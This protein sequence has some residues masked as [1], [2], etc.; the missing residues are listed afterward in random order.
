LNEYLRLETFLLINSIS[1]FPAGRT[2][3]LSSKRG[4]DK[5]W[6]IDDCLKAWSGQSHHVSTLKL[7]LSIISKLSIRRSVQSH[8]IRKG[9]LPYLIELMR[10]PEP[11]VGSWEE[12]SWIAERTMA[13]CMNLALRSETRRRWA[14]EGTEILKLLTDLVEH[15]NVQ[16]KT[17]ANSTLYYLLGDYRF[18]ESASAMGIHDMLKYWMETSSDPLIQMQMKHLCD[19][20]SSNQNEGILIR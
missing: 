19:L 4:L 9:F 7:T 17:Y 11:L 16:V 2:Y 8:L 14:S 10:D 13:L 1:S 18:Q 12:D 20:V 15:E 5:F 6:L 3:L